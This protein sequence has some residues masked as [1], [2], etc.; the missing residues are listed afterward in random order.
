VV[1]GQ[2]REKMSA[3]DVISD[4]TSSR[5]QAEPER[6]ETVT[7]CHDDDDDD[8]DDNID[9][10]DDGCDDDDDDV[11]SDTDACMDETYSR[12]DRPDCV[13]KIDLSWTSDDERHQRTTHVTRHMTTTHVTAQC[14]RHQSRHQTAAQRCVL[15][16]GGRAEVAVKRGRHRQRRGG[17]RY[18]TKHYASHVATTCTLPLTPPTPRRQIV[19]HLDRPE[20]QNAADEEEVEIDETVR[21]PSNDEGVCCLQHEFTYK[22]ANNSQHVIPSHD[23][24]SARDVTVSSLPDDGMMQCA[25]DLSISSLVTNTAAVHVT[26]DVTM[27][28]TG[29]SNVDVNA[30]IFHDECID[31]PSSMSIPRSSAASETLRGDDGDA[32]C[33]ERKSEAENSASLAERLLCSLDCCRCW[34]VSM[35]IYRSTSP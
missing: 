21:A 29:S 3:R 31:P 26:D 28:H 8:D 22:T 30:A 1:R 32:V 5:F 25:I 35:S 27:C 20:T 34:R 15:Q 4:V 16:D 19:R 9:G 17:A 12:P 23:V 33:V 10:A 14:R 11:D 13:P 6:C 24:I 2:C 7:R 18:K